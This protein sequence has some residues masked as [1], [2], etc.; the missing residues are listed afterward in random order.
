MSNKM[1]CVTPLMLKKKT[2]I[3]KPDNGENKKDNE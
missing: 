3:H 2:L 1:Y